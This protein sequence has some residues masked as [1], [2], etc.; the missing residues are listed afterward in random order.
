VKTC[1]V[2]QGSSGAEL[3]RKLLGAMELPEHQVLDGGRRSSAVSLAASIVNHR[4]RPTVLVLDTD[5]VEP[6]AIH[7]QESTAR[8]LFAAPPSVP[9]SLLMAV[10]QVEVVV[11]GQAEA[12]G[13]ILGREPT[14]MELLEARFRPRGVLERL[15]AEVGMDRAAFI[16]RINPRAAGRFAE[17]P[18][19]QSLADFIRHPRAPARK[20]A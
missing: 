16:E 5:T 15:L 18:L 4:P 3:L 14:E 17:H 10:P 2:T 13:C 19:V 8:F 6:G 12:L 9:S 1:V 20:A 11:F 7:E